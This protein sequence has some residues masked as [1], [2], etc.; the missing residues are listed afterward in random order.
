M[1]QT[2]HRSR[3]VMRLRMRYSSGKPDYAR[4]NRIMARAPALSMYRHAAVA[5]SLLISS[6]ATTTLYS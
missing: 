6:M 5:L 4:P 1:L 2:S 3:C